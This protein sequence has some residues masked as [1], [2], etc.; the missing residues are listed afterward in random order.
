MT[1][2]ICSAWGNCPKGNCRHIHRHEYDYTCKDR[3]DKIV[4]MHLA[5]KPY[6]SPS[7][8]QTPLTANEIEMQKR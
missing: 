5:L 1:F 7:I 3:C 8:H 2:Y 4:S 6:C